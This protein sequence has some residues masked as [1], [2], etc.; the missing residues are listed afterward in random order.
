MN[1]VTLGS[2]QLVVVTHQIYKSFDD[3]R[4]WFVF[5]GISRTFDKISCKVLILKL[6]V[7]LKYSHCLLILTKQRVVS[8]D[9]LSLRP[10]IEAGIQQGFILG[11]LLLLI[12][13]NSLLD[14]LITNTRL[15]ADNVSIFSVVDYINL[16]A[17]NL[18]CD[19]NS[20][21]HLAKTCF[22]E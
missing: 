12:Y 6:L 16:S 4:G 9:Q 17:T 11:P 10:S 8:N 21:S 20:D 15:F 13:I 5:S 19:L 7:S 2:Y 3:D 14:S 1:Q 22:Y 18:H